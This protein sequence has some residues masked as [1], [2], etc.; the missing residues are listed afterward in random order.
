MLPLVVTK[1][2]SQID[3]WDAV[4]RQNAPERVGPYKVLERIG[5]GGMGEV[6]LAEQT[7]PVKRRVAVKVIKRGMDTRAIIARFESER[8][9]LALMNHTAIAKVFEA[10]ETGGGRPYF[11]MEYVDGRAITDYCDDQRLKT[12]QRIELLMQAC[13][14][15]QHAHQKGVIHR[16]LKPSNILV[17]VENDRPMPKIID[18]GVAKAT[19]VRLTEKTLYTELGQWIGTPA[20]MSPEQADPT[21]RDIDTR[22]DVYALGVVLYE[23]LV[24][25]RPYDPEDLRRLDFDE[26]RRVLR[27]ED[28]DKPSSRLSTLAEGSEVSAQKRRVDSATLVRTLRG[29]LDAITMKALAKERSRRYGSPLEL[30]ADLGRYLRQEPV[31]ASPP[32]LLYRTKKFVRRHRLA[33]TASISLL[34]L[35]IAAVAGTTFGMLKARD[36]ERLAQK[37]AEVAHRV[38]R[39]LVDLFSVADPT[40]RPGESVTAR[41]LLDEG[42]AQIDDELEG[43]PEVASELYHTIG[44]VYVSLGLFEEGIGHL[45]QAL[46]SRREHYSEASFEVGETLFE[47]GTARTQKGDY[48]EAS[49]SLEKALELFRQ[50]GDDRAEAETLIQLTELRWEEGRYRDGVPLGEL[51][52]TAAQKA[53]GDRS[54]LRARALSALAGVLASSG[55]PVAAE[56]LAREALAVLETEL[57]TRH[58]STISALSDLAHLLDLLDR[59]DES[60]ALYRRVVEGQEHIFGDSHWQTANAYDNLAMALASNGQFE[61][62]D[63]LHHRAAAILTE[64]HSGRHRDLMVVLSNHGRTLFMAGRYREA[65]QRL[66]EAQEIID[67]TFPGPNPFRGPAEYWLAQVKAAGGQIDEARKGFRRAAQ[68]LVDAGG[69]DHPRVAIALY[70]LGALEAEQERFVEAEA[71]LRE[72]LRIF[73]LAGTEGPP[74]RAMSRLGLVLAEQGRNAEAQHLLEN[75]RALL[76]TQPEDDRRTELLAEVERALAELD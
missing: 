53:A 46:A 59:R 54:E 31:E 50:L 30:A 21:G 9:A 6:F 66:T 4:R 15:V 51:A 39:F 11:A 7:E 60:L 69:P 65:A 42:A 58:P 14:G 71:P 56:P 37:E 23:L 18:F 25:A 10:G 20:Y 44:R 2:E 49:A 45:E 47:L 62:A 61:E 26:L 38:S 70:E 8:Q 12:E 1:R 27:E 28:P 68:A 57:G 17:Q 55:D 16:D 52:T 48:E 3:T 74:A 33:A 24:G 29:D 75:G 73:Q 40:E 35:L 43:H 41:E 32:S 19:A 13:E 64:V 22:T 76:L 34:T 36:A 67:Q 72:A 63:D 5:E